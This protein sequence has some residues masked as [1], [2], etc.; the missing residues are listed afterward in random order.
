MSTT[1]RDITQATLTNVKG[2][3][4]HL[5]FDPTHNW[6]FVSALGNNTDEIRILLTNDLY[7]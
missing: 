2:R 7:G 6:L 4:D 5:G 3:I 1:T